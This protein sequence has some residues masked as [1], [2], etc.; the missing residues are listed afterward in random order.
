MN[1]LTAFCNI[2][3]K[4]EAFVED[5]YMGSNR[6][7]NVGEGLEVFIKDVF[8]NIDAHLSEQE[9]LLKYQEVF[10]FLGN[11]NNPPDIMI[12]DGDAIEV[13]KIQ[14]MSSQIALNSSYPKQVLKSDSHFVTNECRN[15]EEWDEK[16]MLYV[17]GSLDDSHDIR[18]LSFVYGDLYSA[19]EEV[20][21]RVANTIKTNVELIE[22]I[23]FVETKELGKVHK[24]DPLG[25]TNLR[26]RGMWH[27][28]N[29]IKV[30]DYLF[31]DINMQDI[32][33]FALMKLEKYNSFSSEDR[34]SLESL[35]DNKFEIL[36]VM[37]KN[38]DNPAQLIESKL[39]LLLK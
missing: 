35:I 39:L 31:P 32:F 25:I 9:K 12:R 11:K 28:E 15:A 8:A 37:V 29:P 6:I 1:I 7:N 4:K 17:I 27:I 13:K 10:S 3:D 23:E 20:Y 34:T 21:K 19:S 26:V 2:V 14:S 30:Y 5:S 22:D 16:D 36:D 18:Y 38:P 33:A 24:V